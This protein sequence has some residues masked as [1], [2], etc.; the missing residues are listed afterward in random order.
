MVTGAASGIG[1]A[2]ARHLAGQG[3]FVTGVD[4]NA[5]AEMAHFQ[6]MH[7]VDLSDAAA[8]RTLADAVAGHDAL[9]HAAGL[10]RTAGHADADPADGDLMWAVHVRALAILIVL[11]IYRSATTWPGVV[12]VLLGVPVYAWWARQQRAA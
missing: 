1:D 11:F 2:F 9:V 3:W 10:M 7:Q 8:T 4:R 6:A 5:P 12:I